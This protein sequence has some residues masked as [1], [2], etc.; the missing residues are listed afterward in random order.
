MSSSTQ[1]EKGSPLPSIFSWL[2]TILV[3][4]ALTMTAVRLMLSPLYIQT[5]YR[6]PGFP[7][8][9][10]GFTQEERL[11]YADNARVYLLNSAGI[12]FLSDLSFA[13]GESLYNERELGH[14]LDVKNV[15]QAALK[16]WYATLILLAGLGAWAWFGGWRREYGRGLGRGGW[17]TVILFGTILVLVILS[18]GFVFVAFH[19]VFFAAGTWTFNYSDTLIRLFPERFWRDIFIAVGGL[20]MLAGFLLGWFFGR[21]RV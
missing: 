17:L 16:V 13:S 10:Y 19:N 21:K 4:I 1:T 9:P 8:D 6:I 15:V 3:P 2:V 11:K 20:T 18:F 12:N 7:D 14:M 5:E